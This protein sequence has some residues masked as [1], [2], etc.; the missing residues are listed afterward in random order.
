MGSRWIV[1]GMRLSKYITLILFVLCSVSWAQRPGERGRGTAKVENIEAAEAAEVIETFRNQRLAGDYVFIFTLKHFLRRA[2]EDYYRGIM[3]GTW[4]ENG[5]ISRVSVWPQGKRPTDTRQLL[6]QGGANPRVWE[7]IDGKVV[8]LEAE[9]QAQPFF[10]GMV[11]S[12]YDILLPFAYW[13]DYEY[14]GSKRTLGQRPAH[15]FVFFA[16][17]GIDA[18]IPG[19]DAVEL[20]LDAD[21]YY[22]ISAAMLDHKGNELRTM[23]EPTFKEIRDQWIVKQVKLTDQGTGDYTNFQVDHAALG[24][25]LSPRIFEPENLARGEPDIGQ[26]MFDPL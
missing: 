10:Q 14:I 13:D 1:P 9:R 6:I 23:G 18:K 24:Q 21:F 17:E 19:L 26:V 25:R 7:L 20:W 15:G 11:Y 4:N 5:P 22:P 3:W 2:G 16:P 12:P 8:E